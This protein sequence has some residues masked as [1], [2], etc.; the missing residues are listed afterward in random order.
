M[1]IRAH[2]LLETWYLKKLVITYL[3]K[4]IKV[5]IYKKAKNYFNSMETIFRLKGR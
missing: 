1:I 3:D 2:Y 5:K 4:G